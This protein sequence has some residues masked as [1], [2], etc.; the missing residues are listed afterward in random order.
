MQTDTFALTPV[1]EGTRTRRQPR[2]VFQKV[3]GKNSPWW[4][5]YVDAQGRFRREKAGTKS[6][7]IDLY[8]RR[9]NEAVEGKKL[10]EKLRRATVSFAEIAKDA[11]AYS[12]AN[13][14]SYGDDVSR[15]ETLLLWFREYPAEGITAQDIERRFEQQTWAPATMNRQRALLSLTYRLAIRNGKVKENPARQVRHRLENNARIRFLS[16]EEET[17]LRAAMEAACPERIAEL[18]L[19]LN[20]G[21]RRSEQYRLCW[22]DVSLARRT[23][24]IARSKNGSAR[25][26]ALNKSALTALGSLRER[27]AIPTLFAAEPWGLSAGLSQS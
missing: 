6:A 25:H 5:R 27:T 2:G 1:R 18:E 15:M 20:T 7:A 23:L 11:L 10:P 21:L 19:A 24:T 16:P 4:I 22:Q 13:K 17:K 12:K 26:V 9:K 8:R 14:L 3:P